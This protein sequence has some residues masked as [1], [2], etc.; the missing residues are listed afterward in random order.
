MKSVRF[1]LVLTFF[2]SL[3]TS[4]ELVEDAIDDDVYVDVNGYSSDSEARNA[5][6]ESNAKQVSGI[7]AINRLIDEREDETYEVAGMRFQLGASDSLLVNFGGQLHN[8]TWRLSADSRSVVMRIESSLY[9]VRELD[10]E[11]FIMEITE[12]EMKLHDPGDD[13]GEWIYLQKAVSL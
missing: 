11:W 13:G 2:A 7:W 1:M 6:V 8:G 3:F 12:N 4:C 5:A 9:G 10:D